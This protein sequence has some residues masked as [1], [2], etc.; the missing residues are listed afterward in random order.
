MEVI[1]IEIKQRRKK[2]KLVVSLLNDDD[3]EQLKKK[4]QMMQ[5]EFDKGLF[6]LGHEDDKQ[7][8]LGLLK[9]IDK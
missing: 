4:G 6:F 7:E 8:I 1:E 5:G 2:R 9:G 3:I